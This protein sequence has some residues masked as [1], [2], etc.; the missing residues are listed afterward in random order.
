MSWLAIRFRGGTFRTFLGVP[1][2]CASYRLMPP[3][4]SFKILGPLP[5]FMSLSS[6][7]FLNC[8]NLLVKTSRDNAR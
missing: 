3:Q 5:G 1:D 7:Y 8:L 6:W 4:Y 2:T